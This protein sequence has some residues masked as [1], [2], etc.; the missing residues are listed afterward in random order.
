LKTVNRAWLWC[1]GY[2]MPDAKA[3]DKWSISRSLREAPVRR[4]WQLYQIYE[5]RK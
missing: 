1:G 4:P 3:S 2:W 5:A